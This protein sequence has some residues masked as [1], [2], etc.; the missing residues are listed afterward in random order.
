LK[1]KRPISRTDASF[2]YFEV[3]ILHAGRDGYAICF[4]FFFSSSARLLRSLYRE[5]PR[6]PS[7]LRILCSAIAVGLVPAEDAPFVM[8]GWSPGSYGYHGDDGN[9]YAGG[10]WNSYGP[11]F[12]AGDVIGCG[13]ANATGEI[14]FTKNGQLIDVAFRD[15]SAATATADLYFA[16]GV[17][18]VTH[19]PVFFFFS[20]LVPPLSFIYT[21]GI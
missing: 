20:F 19:S 12:G 9:A 21:C 1:A 10:S 13:L 5:R 4:F 6:D 15:A 2:A 8:P 18:S 17:H 3:L 7:P 14:F 16:V 11:P